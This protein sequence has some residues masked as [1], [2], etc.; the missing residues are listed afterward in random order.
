MKIKIL[1]T[2]AAA[3]FASAVHAAEPDQITGRLTIFTTDGAMHQTV[4]T[5]E[6]A[7]AC[8]LRTLSERFFDGNQT[9]AQV[10]CLNDRDE[11]VGIQ[12]CDTERCVSVK[13]DEGVDSWPMLLSLGR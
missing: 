13:P 12:T 10:L 5:D 1:N 7:D 3:S 6:S 9:T 4:T 11:W 8:M 2:I